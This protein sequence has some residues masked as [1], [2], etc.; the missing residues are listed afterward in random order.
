MTAVVTKA[1]P[2]FLSGPISFSSLRNTFKETA[3]GQIK[4][5]ELKRNT[6]STEENPIVPDCTENADISSSSN[7]S[8]SQFRNSIKYYYITQSGL[9]LNFDITNQSWNNNLNKNIKKWLYIS[10]TCASNSTSSAAAILTVTTFNLTIDVFGLIY[11][12]GGAG[13]TS[14]TISGGKGGD[15]LSITS[16]TANNIV[17]FLRPEGQIYAGGGG[18]EKGLKG[19]NGSNGYCIYYTYYERRRCRRC[20]NCDSGDVRLYCYNRQGRCSLFYQYREI[21]CR[22]TNTVFISGGIGGEGGNG[23]TGRGYNNL[24]GSLDGAAGAAGTGGGCSGYDAN[25]NPI[26]TRGQNG[27][28][29]GD[30][31]DWGEDGYPTNNTGNGGIAGKAIAGLNYT[32]DGSITGSTIRGFYRA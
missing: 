13:G 23:A 29:G 19:E 3:S 26:P 25:G 15:A 12:A 1:G 27:E 10:G 31:G 9:D 7:L 2:Y 6:S 16:P 18:G 28:T 22:R 8:V 14:T 4:A 21:K 32:V 20:P 11:G 5:S 24:Y 17:V 30:G